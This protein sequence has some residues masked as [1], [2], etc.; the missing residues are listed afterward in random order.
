[1]KLKLTVDN[2][3]TADQLFQLGALFTGLAIGQGTRVSSGDV[4]PVFTVPADPAEL[5][6]PEVVEV[7]AGAEKPKR[8]R[9]TKAEIEAEKL[10]E[11]NAA[12]AAAEAAAQESNEAAA[13]E[14]GN[15][16]PAPTQP[17]PETQSGAPETPVAASPSE[18]AAGGKSYNEAEVQDLAG[19]V[20]RAV[21]PEV[22]KGK[23][24]ELGASRIAEL[25]Q[26][27]RDALGAFLAA[28]LP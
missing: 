2:S 8:N 11:E 17:A 4:E 23:I 1:M 3:T 5:T 20:A 26:E 10:A 12:V 28:Q 9:R 21:G 18:P 6:E 19:K 13:A 24:A 14:V 16:Q 27:Q 22:V 7:P 25:T 15:A